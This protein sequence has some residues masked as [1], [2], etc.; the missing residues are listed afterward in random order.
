MPY[1][2]YHLKGTLFQSSNEER[3]LLEIN[4]VFQHAD[5][6]QARK[7]AHRK[8]QSYVDVLLE[9]LG[10][11][12]V[13]DEQA[14]QDL[15]RFMKSNNTNKFK[16]APELKV[17]VDFDKGLYLYFIPDSSQFYTSQEGEKLYKLKYMVRYIDNGAED[18]SST[19]KKNAKI[20]RGI[21]NAMV[22][23]EKTNDEEF[24]AIIEKLSGNKR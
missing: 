14:L 15:H 2:I 12:Y 1:P 9:S 6:L 13:N 21:I 10:F 19:V 24:N 22:I 23:K 18:F 5:I 11:T 20:E 16:L 8:F 3:S 4:E 17:D 7:N